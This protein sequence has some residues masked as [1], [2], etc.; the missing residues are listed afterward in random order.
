M[1][2]QFERIMLNYQKLPIVKLLFAGLIMALLAQ[3]MEEEELGWTFYLESPPPPEITS[4]SST[5]KDCMPPYPVTFYQ[6]TE[7]LLGHVNYFWDFGDGNTSTLQNPTHIYDSIGSYDVMLTVSNEIG[8]DTMYLDMSAL[9]QTSI[10]VEAGF[11]YEH[12]NDNNYAP[13]K[14]IFSN[15]SSGSK[16]FDWDF[17][18]GGQDNDDDPEHVFDSE[19]IYTVTLTGTC[20]SDES[21]VYTQQIYINSPPSRIYVDALNLMLPSN[22]RNKRIYVEIYHNTT[23]I[24]STR[25]IS[26]S[27]YPVKFI[28]PED[29]Y[30]APIFEFVSFAYNEVFKFL[31]IEEIAEADDFVIYEIVLAPVDIQNKFYPKEYFQIE[32]VPALED[33]FID[34]YLKY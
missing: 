17:G 29:F 28:N 15:T 22:L 30:D 10:P 26:A 6:E 27:S 2:I 24:G 9:N 34:L 16:F 12:F 23:Y 8:A 33:V 20:T 14:V 11:S 3:C 32:H 13:S 21:D 25:T 19:G 7:N 4:V 31:V 5:I 1:K 18:D